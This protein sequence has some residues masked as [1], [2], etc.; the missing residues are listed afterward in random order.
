VS[1]N[2]ESG[3]H[4]M[5]CEKESGSEKQHMLVLRNS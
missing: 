1:G 2:D 4:V 5:H 3:V